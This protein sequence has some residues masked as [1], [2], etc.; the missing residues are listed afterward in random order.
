LKSGHPYHLAG[1]LEAFNELKDKFLFIFSEAHLDDL[2]KSL[3]DYRDKDLD[4]MGEYVKDNFFSFDHVSEKTFQCLLATPKEAFNSKDYAAVRKFEKDPWN[5]DNLLPDN[6]EM[7]EINAINKLLK[8]YFDLPITAL[9][10]PLDTSSL[11]QKNKEWIDKILPGYHPEMSIREFME[12]MSGF[13]S[14][15]LTDDKQLTELRRFIRDYVDRDK[16]SFEK[17]GMEFDEKFKETGFGKTFLEMV[18]SSLGESQK[19]NFYQRFTSAYSMLEVYN[20]TQERKS[21]GG[22]KK[23]DFSSLSTDASHAYYASF[24][25]YLVTDDKG[26]QAKA[27]IMYKLFDIPTKIVSIKE[28][29][30]MRSQLAGQEETI[31]RFRE[32]INYDINHAL[33][34]KDI[35]SFK[36]DSK[37]TTYKT[38][39]SYFNYFNRFQIIRDQHGTSIVFYC[40]RLGYGNFVMYR[41]IELLINKLISLFGNDIERKGSYSLAEN[42]H[43]ADYQI[44][45]KWRFEDL[46]VELLDSNHPWGNFMCLCLNF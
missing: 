12:S 18:D 19:N 16:Y 37:I 30:N 15:L 22:L 29:I 31:Y 35:Y 34:I 32:A 24:C 40:E 10:T 36:T 1:L 2:S 27:H 11:D 7:P 17:W 42:S 26:L 5:I 8:S 39:H 41:E 6:P 33:L 4:F 13:S 44:F 9:A 14:A 45:R 21:S 23:F 3:P 38:S 46:T 20:I 28:F 25:D 43:T